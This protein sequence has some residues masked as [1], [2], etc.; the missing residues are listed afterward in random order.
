VITGKKGGTV[1]ETVTT[2]LSADG[3]TQNATTVAKAAD[4]TETT[5]EAVWTRQ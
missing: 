3:N 4:G 1:V 2:K 5:S